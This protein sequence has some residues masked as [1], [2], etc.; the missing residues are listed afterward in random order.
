MSF[1]KRI[2]VFK[3]QVILTLVIISVTWVNFNQV[4]W[5]HLD[6]VKHDV[7]N[8]YSY[9]PAFF[10]EKDLSLSFLND[11]VNQK[12]EKQFYAPNYTPEG[13]PVIKMSMGMS[14]SYLP[15]FA[16]AHVYAKYFNYPVNGFSEPYQ[17]ALQFSSLFYYLLGL[18][19]LWKVLRIYFS[20]E[21]S[22]LTLFLISFATNVFFYLTI[23]AAMSHIVGF[24]FISMFI[25]FTI[26]WHNLFQ[27]KHLLLIGFIGGCLTLVRPINFL[28]FLFF[29]LY[30]IQNPADFFKRIHL[31]LEKK[32]MIL[33][34]CVLAF[35]IVLPQ[36]L[37]WHYVSGHYF[38]NSYVGEHFFFN[39]PHFVEALVGFRKG[40][41]IYTPIMLFSLV[42]FFVVHQYL[43][44]LSFALMVF[45]GIYVYV[46]FSWWCWWYG[47]SFSQRVMIDIYPFLA[48][49]FAAFITH[50]SVQQ[51]RVK[52]VVGSLFVFFTL[53][54]LFQTMQAKYNIIHYDSMTVENYFR[55][56]G[57]ITT[58]PDANKYLKI[59]DYES[60]KLGKEERITK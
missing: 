7:V 14:V 46:A 23:I 44:T 26:K 50:L 38:F 41:L 52:Q 49:P 36:L 53:L 33:V 30:G 9:L 59:P 40:W 51:K 20:K 5:K 3:L 12:I 35:L 57:T 10:Y 8:Y 42:G 27:W 1:I 47:G 58:K 39:K 34:M 43:K 55:V 45:V 28:V 29:A 48:I 6:V 4:L 22:T 17:F 18:W 31:F 11:T 32:W 16:L 15:F 56:F 24:A 25:Y 13:K 37:Y 2:N 60:A 21:T 19:F 54:N